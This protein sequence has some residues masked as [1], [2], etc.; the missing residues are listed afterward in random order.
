MSFKKA[1]KI[2]RNVQNNDPNSSRNKWQKILTEFPKRFWTFLTEK[3]QVFQFMQ[4]CPEKMLA[5][6][7][8]LDLRSEKSLKTMKFQPMKTTDFSIPF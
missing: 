7:S 8:S 5:K 4:D 3:Y 1:T 6:T 2:I